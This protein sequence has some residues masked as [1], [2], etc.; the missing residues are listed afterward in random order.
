MVKV[1]SSVVDPVSPCLLEPDV[2]FSV[3]APAFL[4]PPMH[5]C[6]D[7]RHALSL[8]V[9]R[10]HLS[11][12]G[13]VFLAPLAVSRMHLSVAGHVF[14]A[15]QVCFLAG[16]RVFSVVLGSSFVDACAGL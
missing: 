16:D 6:V 8:A 4:E 13:H 5:S 3:V 10:M 12:A 15:P 14:L 7:D 11:E 2:D 1:C 9:S